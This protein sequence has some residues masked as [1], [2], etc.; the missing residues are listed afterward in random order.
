MVQISERSPDIAITRCLNTQAEVDVIK[1]N[2]EFFVQAAYL[3]INLAPNHQARGRYGGQ[4]LQGNSSIEIAKAAT[5]E[6]M[7][8]MPCYTTQTNQDASV[9]QSIVWVPECS[10]HGTSTRLHSDRH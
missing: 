4:I 1:G 7:V 10:T 8:H 5:L 3:L 9:L 2:G 6:R